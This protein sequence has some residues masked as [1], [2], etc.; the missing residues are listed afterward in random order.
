MTT[1]TFYNSFTKESLDGTFD[2]DSNT[3]KVML[4]TSSYTFNRDTHDRRDDITNE[5]TG[6]GYTAG[7]VALTS[8]LLTQDN[9]NDRTLF[10]FDNPE[11]G[12]TASISGIRGAVIY[13]DTGA[14][15]TDPL[16][17]FIDFEGDQTVTGGTFRIALDALG[18]F[19]H[20]QV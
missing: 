14:A 19:E 18:L 12:P 20:K 1:V 10:D 3:L 16:M 11:W 8:K 7:G 6:T 9:T 17:C 2:L 15:A 5:V 4:V 13:K